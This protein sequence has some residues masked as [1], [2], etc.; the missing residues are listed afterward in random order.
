MTRMLP[1]GRIGE[2][3]IR[4]APRSKM[5]CSRLYHSVG[6]STFSAVSAIAASVLSTIA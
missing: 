6:G 3:R 1:I 5:P 2:E 4:W